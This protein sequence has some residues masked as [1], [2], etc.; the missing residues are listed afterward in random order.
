MYVLKFDSFIAF[1]VRWFVALWLSSFTRSF[2][3][4]FRLHRGLDVIRSCRIGTKKGNET[5]GASMGDG[6]FFGTFP[7]SHLSIPLMLLDV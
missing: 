6:H 2:L 5:R 4:S 7:T 1:D 3:C